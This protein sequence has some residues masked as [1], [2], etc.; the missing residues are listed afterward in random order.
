[1]LAGEDEFVELFDQALS[2][3]DE[4]ADA[5]Q[6]ARTR[7]VYGERLR[8][9]RQR[10]RAREQLRAALETFERL[11]AAP[12][13]ERARAE[14]AA[15]GETARR[16]DPTTVDQLTPQELQIGML[17]GSGRTTRQAA[18][19]LFLSPKT[20]EY[21]LRSIYRKLGIASREELARVLAADPAPTAEP[22]AA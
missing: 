11:D 19:A 7:L 8:R 3:H 22:T 4:T 17:L 5:F 18:A 13:A 6:V 15:T 2:L 21:H 16:R 10:V 20:I 14:L 12:W 1:M 9:N